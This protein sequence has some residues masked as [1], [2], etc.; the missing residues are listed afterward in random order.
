MKVCNRRNFDIGKAATR[1]AKCGRIRKP[2]ALHADAR[3]ARTNARM[4]ATAASCE[5]KHDPSGSTLLSIPAEVRS[6]IL[7]TLLCKSET[8]A[9]GDKS[10][11]ANILAVCRQLRR[12]ASVLL[13]EQ[14]TFD[15]VISDGDQRKLHVKLLNH[16]WSSFDYA[17]EVPQIFCLALRWRII[18][19]GCQKHHPIDDDDSF[20]DRQAIH[21]LC[22]L[23]S[24]NVQFENVTLSIHVEYEQE[25]DED[26]YIM[27][28][29]L[30]PFTFLRGLAKVDVH[31]VDS[32]Y[33]RYVEAQMISQMPVENI[34]KMKDAFWSWCEYR[35]PENDPVNDVGAD[36]LEA[37]NDCDVAKFKVEREKA[38]SQ[39]AGRYL[40]STERVYQY[41]MENGRSA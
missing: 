38:V 9:P 40:R 5:D 15:I 2:A 24:D 28:Q 8:L 36:A 17:Y 16:A 26:N 29:V 35:N 23:L 19:R 14:N 22:E 18:L 37:I 12:E 39:L 41:D 25:Y 13:Y 1:K 20:D 30:Q 10:P 21:W 3:C 33:A 31:G 7:K 34:W 4:Q 11:A 27:D 6:D 32:A